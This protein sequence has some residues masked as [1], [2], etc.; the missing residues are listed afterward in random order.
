MGFLSE[1]F[2]KKKEGPSES[3]YENG[4]VPR[5]FFSIGTTDTHYLV[6]LGGE[7]LGQG[8]HDVW[9]ERVA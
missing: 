2:G 5:E 9:A 1:L 3:Y 4:D 6:T 7:H 8:H